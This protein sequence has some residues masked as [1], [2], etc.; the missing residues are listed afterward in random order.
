MAALVIALLAVTFSAGAAENPPDPAQLADWEARLEK[1]AALQRDGKAR[2]DAASK[3]FEKKNAEC[4]KAF[5][6]Y[7]CQETVQA[8]YVA[9]ANEGQRLD[10]EGRAMERQVKKEQ[11]SDKALRRAAEV[12]KREAEL[13]VRASDTAA[14]RKAA[15]EAEAEAATRASKSVKAEEGL[16]RRAADAE[17][18]QKKRADHEARHARQVE[19]AER[20]AAEAAAKSEQ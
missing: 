2:K 16:K 19:K 10:N 14:E 4:F 18:Q 8:E 17:R 13:D 9:E 12:P 11:A 20:R 15:A 3:L 1:A 7:A 6:V 5:R